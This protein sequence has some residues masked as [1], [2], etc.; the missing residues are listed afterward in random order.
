MS[1]QDPS[2]PLH[3][4]ACP[5]MVLWTRRPCCDPQ[6]PTA[7]RN[8]LHGPPVHSHG[9]FSCCFEEGPLPWDA[10]SVGQAKGESAQTS[11]T[12]ISS[13]E[14]LMPAQN[15][16]SMNQMTHCLRCFAKAALSRPSP[17][18]NPSVHMCLAL[19][20]PAD[21]STQS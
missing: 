14:N 11:I 15:S 4:G 10:G 5:G 8:P 17:W 9:L 21:V 13:K 1:D 6:R 3:V 20:R 16:K 2:I 12:V 18:R 19:Q 7:L